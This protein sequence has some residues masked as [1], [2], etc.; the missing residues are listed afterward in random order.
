LDGLRLAFYKANNHSDLH[1]AKVD[2]KEMASLF[3]PTVEEFPVVV[4]TPAP[5]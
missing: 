2:S 3:A 4:D 5:G 1:R